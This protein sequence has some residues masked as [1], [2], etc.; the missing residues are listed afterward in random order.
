MNLKN[1]FRPGATKQIKAA[2]D[3]TYAPISLPCELEIIAAA[4][5]DTTSVPS[6]KLLAYTGGLMTLMGWDYPVVV[7]LAG[8]DIPS[9]QLPA[10]LQHDPAK[11]VGHT[12]KITKTKTK[13]TAEGILSRVNEYSA[14][15]RE[16][17]RNGFP[18]RVSMGARPGDVLFAGE[19]QK[20]KANGQTFEGPVY[21][22]QTSV[23]G[24][25]SFVDLGADS[26]TSAAIAAQSKTEN[27]SSN[28]QEKKPMA[29]VKEL[30]TCAEEFNGLVEKQ[31]IDSAVLE[32]A[33]SEQDVATLRAGLFKKLQLV[34]VRR[35][36]VNTIG[37]AP[38]IHGGGMLPGDPKNV[39]A[40][41]FLLAAGK[42]SSAEKAFSAEELQAASDLRP[43]GVADIA[44]SA[45][46]SLGLSVP[47]TRSE[48]I[49]AAFSTADLSN[50]LAIANQAVLREAFL[51]IEMTCRIVGSKQ[52]ADNF[53][54]HALIEVCGI[55]TYPLV[56]PSGELKHTSFQDSKITFAPKTRGALFVISRTDLINDNLGVF[57]QISKIIGFNASRT[58]N[59]IFWTVFKAASTFF[60]EARGNL[61]KSAT[62]TPTT[63]EAAINAARNMKD[64]DNN[65]VGTTP[66]YLTVP[67]ALEMTARQIVNSIEIRNT[68]ADTK[69]GTGNPLN[70]IVEIVVEPLLGVLFGGL[71]SSWYVFNDK[72]VTPGML[73]SYLNG[74]DTPTVESAPADF[75]TLGVQLR[76]YLDFGV[77]TGDF[78]GVIKG[79]A[80]S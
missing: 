44:R 48:L 64:A 14:D 67:P 11:G 79:Q 12:T 42:H 73:L 71:D 70:K 7:E 4:A 35:Q 46:Q 15:V 51:S 50:S 49:R 8:M 30:R 62:L 43:H 26:E 37:N 39:F 41:A 34:Q 6:F 77:D 18:W 68:E 61:L 57:D 9:Q 63:L 23:L 27:E 3:K 69:Y 17:S 36:H 58:E 78:R 55:S 32:A 13:L 38:M 24:E 47:S 76:A 80:A 66:R 28:I 72:L 1:I 25:L 60:T 19:K 10:R 65:P 31:Q 74:I 59:T 54:E 40:A 21:L 5:G 53:K 2:A 22:V 16:S 56:A 75:D 45:L 52:I 20:V 29:T 33:E